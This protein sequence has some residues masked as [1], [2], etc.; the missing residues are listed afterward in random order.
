MHESRTQK[1]GGGWGKPGSKAWVC[2]KE[3]GRQSK[4][5]RGPK[6]SREVLAK[7]KPH[8]KKKKKKTPQHPDRERM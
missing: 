5:E 4:E 8:A 6:E 7:E 3:F 2:V 1:G